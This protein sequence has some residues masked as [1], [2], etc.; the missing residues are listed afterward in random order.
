VSFSHGSFQCLRQPPVRRPVGRPRKNAPALL[1]A[2]FPTPSRPAGPASAPTTSQRPLKR[3]RPR[4]SSATRDHDAFVDH[5]DLDEFDGRDDLESLSP[6][7]RTAKRKLSQAQI[8][9]QLAVRSLPSPPSTS[10]GRT[11][12]AKVT[13]REGRVVSAF[14]SATVDSGGRAKKVRRVVE[15][16]SEDGEYT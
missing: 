15:E 16:D 11:A 1:A 9:Q 8:R 7:Q 10:N 4:A 5:D 6:V 13:S 12:A 14:T 2:A 3:P